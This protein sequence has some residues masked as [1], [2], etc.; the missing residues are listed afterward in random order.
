M[1]SHPT[2]A[3]AQSPY[4]FQGERRE[5]H[6]GSSELKLSTY[7][8]R[9]LLIALPM[10]FILLTVIFFVMRI[11][12]G[13]P[14]TIMVGEKAPPEEMQRIR[15]FLGLDRPIEVQFYSFLGDMFT[16][17]FG[18]SLVTH[19]PVILE[20]SSAYPATV[21]LAVG[22]TLMGVVIGI[23]LG[24]VTALKRG[25][26]VDHSGRIFT[27]WTYSMPEFWLGT[28]LQIYFA[29]QF[30]MLPTSG[31]LPATMDLRTITG[32]MTVDS[33]LQRNLGA[34][35]EAIRYLILPTVTLGLVTLMPQVSRIARASMLD[36]MREDY[37]ITARAKGLPEKI[38]LYRHALR[39]ALLPIVSIIGLSFSGLLG[40]TVLVE[41]IFSFPGLGRLLVSGLLNR[42]FPV[43]QA[44][45]FM[46]AIVVVAVNTATDVLFAVLDPRVRY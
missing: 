41:T 13:D 44:I 21:E 5:Y 7:V 6:A 17:N 18:E 24:L 4:L 11:L 27:F 3:S 28:L 30:G 26:V 45:V 10:L 16:G 9:R 35:V 20:L 12:P 39:N 31:R 34:F 8:I 43:V 36:Q 22:A 32:L 15:H 29:V 42:D 2:R 46:F 33:L 19:R 1:S 37:I 14:V 23:P 38:V 40:G 25:S